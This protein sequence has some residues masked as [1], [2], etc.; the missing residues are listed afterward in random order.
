MTTALRDGGC[1]PILVVYDPAEPAVS[2]EARRLEVEAGVITL[3]NPEPGEGP[4]TSLRLALSH[5]PE[6][7]EGVAWLP[8]DYPLVDGPVVGRLLEA[9]AESGAP[10]TLPMHA[11][12]RGHPALFRRPLFAE[13]VD[14][15]L[16][17]GARIVVH[18]HLSEACIVPFDENAVVIDVDTPEAYDALLDGVRA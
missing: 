8:L 5:L 6:H 9:A 17:G 10:L 7:C 1:D 15:E 13:L 4:I 18:R 16:A 12:K 2:A 11:E 14:P 3:E